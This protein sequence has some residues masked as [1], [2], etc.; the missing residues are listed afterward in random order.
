MYAL[1]EE[2]HVQRVWLPNENYPGLAMSRAFGDFI[3]KDFGVI[4]IPDIFYHPLTSNDQF[5]VLAS[6]GVRIIICT[7]PLCFFT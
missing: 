7:K 1:K 5:I 2:A 4:A 6:D 3:L